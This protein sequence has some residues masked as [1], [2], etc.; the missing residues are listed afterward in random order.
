MPPTE[1]E[2]AIPA[3]DPPHTYAFDG[4]A[5]GIGIKEMYTF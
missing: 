4:A 1:F 2:P 3:G 5:T